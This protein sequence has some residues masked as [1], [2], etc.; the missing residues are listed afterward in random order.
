MLKKDEI[1]VLKVLLSNL[2]KDFTIMDISRELKQKYVQTYRT[3]N[4][5]HIQ[6]EISIKKV[7]KSKVAKLDL[8]RFNP[9]YVLA[10]LE[11]ANDICKRSTMKTMR[12]S[13]SDINKNF[14]CILFGSQVDKHKEKSDIDLLFLISEDTSIEKFE[15]EARNNMVAHN[16]DINI[17]YYK[18]LH[19]M[20]S[21]PEKLNIGNEM[22]KKHIVLYGTEH[23]L[24]LLRK[25]YVG[26]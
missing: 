11:R 18:S 12:E 7:G 20:L 15:R 16:A 4:N 13:I 8:A 21:H 1:K 9:N 6:K 3:V 26:Q 17:A 5:L 19:E 10:E 25:H 23:F 14:I 2:T 24:N 22:L